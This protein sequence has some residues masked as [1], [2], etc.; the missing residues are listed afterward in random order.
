MFLYSPI[1]DPD[2]RVW[3]ACSEND[4]LNS[5]LAFHERQGLN[6]ADLRHHAILHVV[7]ENQLAD[8]VPAMQE[9]LEEL[10]QD[11]LDR[12]EAI[13]ALG[14]VVSRLFTRMAQKQDIRPD[15]R[16]DYENVLAALSVKSWLEQT[17]K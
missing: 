12:H 17:R 10:I 4:R 1:Q 7:V 11:G 8:Q 3:L 16:L 13:H 2:T 15:A 5:V 9:K 6:R 14:S